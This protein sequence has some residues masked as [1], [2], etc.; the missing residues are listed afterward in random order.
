[1]LP[2]GWDLARTREH[3]PGARP[4][5]PS[6][7]DVLWV[8]GIDQYRRLEAPTLI[9][10]EGLYLILAE[11][12]HGWWTGQLDHSSGSIVCWGPTGPTMISVRHSRPCSR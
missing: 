7:H 3:V 6:A 9:D 11:P 5:D 8:S 12:E 1:M 10:C 2:A 4:L